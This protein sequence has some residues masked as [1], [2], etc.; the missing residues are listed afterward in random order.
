M[1]DTEDNELLE[2]AT[3]TALVAK[4][5]AQ[6]HCLPAT[7]EE[8]RA[9]VI[10]GTM[11]GNYVLLSIIKEPSGDRY[12]IAQIFRA[13]C[14]FNPNYVAIISY[15]EGIQVIDNFKHF[16]LFNL[17]EDIMVARL[18]HGWGVYCHN[19]V[20]VHSILDFKRKS[21]AVL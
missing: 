15:Q 7:S 11:A 6:S 18:T 20:R 8:W 21:S 10:T 2:E 17:G 1:F 13:D 19:F 9:H 16:P 4:A 14:L 3:E 5:A 12:N